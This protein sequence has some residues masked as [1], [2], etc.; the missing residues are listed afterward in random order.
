[1]EIGALDPNTLEINNN[2]EHN[3]FTTKSNKDKIFNVKGELSD[4]FWDLVVSKYNSANEL[5]AMV[6]DPVLDKAIGLVIEDWDSIK[7]NDPEAATEIFNYMKEAASAVL[8]TRL[9]DFAPL[10][11]G[12]KLAEKI[13]SSGLRLSD[14]LLA[15]LSKKY[16]NL[17]LRVKADKFVTKILE[18]LGR[19]CTKNRSCRDK[20][21]YDNILKNDKH[22][23]YDCLKGLD[24]K[25]RPKDNYISNGGNL[26][27]HA[28]PIH[29]IVEANGRDESALK[30]LD[31]LNKYKVDVDGSFNGV[32]LPTKFHGTFNS[33]QYGK[34]ILRDLNKATNNGK[35][36]IDKGKKEVEK[37]LLEKASELHN[38]AMSIYGDFLKCNG[39]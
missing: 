22:P 31:L 5:I 37:M 3:L 28:L 10:G 9:E 24:F 15:K 1:L 25:N 11:K 32:L 20:N 7:A 36:P 14:K 26:K 34:S 8:P 13:G 12:A 35:L 29:H 17:N 27:T 30:S 39:K 6:E 18:S 19:K 33:P 23:Q 16:P 4:K 2:I 21:L 38:Q